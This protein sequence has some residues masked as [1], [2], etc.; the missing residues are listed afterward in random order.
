MS[1]PAPF[2]ILG[3]YRVIHLSFWMM[4]LIFNHLLHQLA[5]ERVM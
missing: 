1:R 2:L 5:G 3:R 4:I